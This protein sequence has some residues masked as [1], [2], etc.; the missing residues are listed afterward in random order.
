MPKVPGIRPTNVEHISTTR[1]NGPV[2]ARVTANS[3]AIT[4]RFALPASTR[5]SSPDIALPDQTVS[6][7]P[8]SEAVA[9]ESSISRKPSDMNPSRESPA[10]SPMARAVPDLPLPDTESVTSERT[11]VTVPTEATVEMKRSGWSSGNT[12]ADIDAPTVDV[13]PGNHPATVPIRTPFRPGTIPTGS[14][15]RSLCTGIPD[16]D[17]DSRRTGIPKRPVS[18]GSMT[19]PSPRMPRIGISRVMQ[20]RPSIPDTANAAAPQRTLPRR[21]SDASMTPA[22]ASRTMG[23][24][25]SSL[26]SRPCRSSHWSGTE[27]RTAAEAPTR[28]PMAADLT[29][30]IPRPCLRSLCPGSTDT[31][32]SPLGAPMKTDGTKSTNEWTTEADIM[33]QQTAIDAASASSC[34]DTADTIAGW[35]VRSI[36]ASVFTWIP[37]ASPLKSPS[38]APATVI[39]MQN[40]TRTGSMRGLCARWVYE[41]NR[42]TQH[43]RRLGAPPTELTA[44]RYLTGT[45]SS[46]D[47]PDTSFC[48]L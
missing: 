11:E 27:S 13:I 45:P 26:S 38:P 10:I 36:D 12:A 28:L 23:V 25:R 17:E 32:S 1:P 14:T 6:R 35:T 21:C 39:T 33:Q 30:A 44:R 15:S 22:A 2:R 47:S 34:P 4:Q 41:T 7:N 24:R 20:A 19:L 3:T 5:P 18:I 46:S 42:V 9:V 8:I 40:P 48:L 31:A 37:G 29:A 43:H 16:D